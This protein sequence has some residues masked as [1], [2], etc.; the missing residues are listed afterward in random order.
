[1]SRFKAFKSWL[2]RAWTGETEFKQVL[3]DYEDY[4][5]LFSENET[6][7][8]YSFRE[9]FNHTRAPGGRGNYEGY[10]NILKKMGTAPERSKYID[11]RQQT[12]KNTKFRDL[13]Y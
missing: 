10:A 6:P 8:P 4:L 3:G 2:N 1:M 5:S 13:Y 7:G 11:L 12:R 9:Y